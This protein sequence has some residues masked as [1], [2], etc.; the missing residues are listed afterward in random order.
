TRYPFQGALY[1]LPPEVIKECIMGAI[2]ARFGTLNEQKENVPAK[3]STPPSASGS[4]AKANGSS[5]R[6]AHGKGSRDG[7]ARP[8]GNGQA[9]VKPA[10]DGASASRCAA[11]DVKDCCGDG[12][13]ERTARLVPA[14]ET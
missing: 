10:A 11:G 14:S 6:S 5:N 13:L 1:G 7:V 4:A 9:G 3:A 8:N 12:V 2:E